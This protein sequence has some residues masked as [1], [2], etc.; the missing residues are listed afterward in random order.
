LHIL[1]NRAS[2]SPLKRYLIYFA[3][4]YNVDPD[5]LY[6]GGEPFLVR[7][8]FPDNS[9]IIGKDVEIQVG[10]CNEFQCFEA[11]MDYDMPISQMKKLFA[12]S[13]RCV[14]KIDFKCKLAPLKVN[15]IL[16][17]PVLKCAY[18]RRG[19]LAS[20]SCPKSFPLFSFHCIGSF[21][22]RIFR[23]DILSYKKRF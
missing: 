19:P 9:T 2:I 17:R 15:E 14:Q 23:I 22:D 16:F 12:L 11:K 13:G 6:S 8:S 21:G 18:C 1:K 7:C 5:G 3:G 4:K 10:K 20:M